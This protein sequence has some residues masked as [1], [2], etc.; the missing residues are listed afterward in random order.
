MQHSIQ[1]LEQKLCESLVMQSSPE[2][3]MYCNDLRLAIKVLKQYQ[4]KMSKMVEDALLK[5]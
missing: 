2:A 5:N 1:I 3:T 4:D